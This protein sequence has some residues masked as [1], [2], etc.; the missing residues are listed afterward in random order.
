[1]QDLDSFQ[2][3][4]GAAKAKRGV[5]EVVWLVIQV[6]LVTGFSVAFLY[7]FLLPLCNFMFQCGCTWMWEGATDQCNAFD[8]S[9]PYSCPWCT[10]SETGARVSEISMIISMVVT[11]LTVM[12]ISRLLSVK[13]A[14]KRKL[15]APWDEPEPTPMS[16]ITIKH[17]LLVI[18]SLVGSVLAFVCSGLFIGLVL[19]L[20]S[21][22]YPHFIF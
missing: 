12:Y 16:N 13:I 18:V 5:V 2:E 7:V 22:D 19:Y 1:M 9:I 10:I 4:A 15:D 17:L 3:P 21:S 20:S 11:Y 8:D 6:I 14:N